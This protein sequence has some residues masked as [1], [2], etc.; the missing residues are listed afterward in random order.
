[1][2]LSQQKQMEKD[3]GEQIAAENYDIQAED[4]KEDT[5]DEED[6]SVHEKLA[7]EEYPSSDKPAGQVNADQTE[8]TVT[9]SNNENT[10]NEQIKE[11]KQPQEEG[12]KDLPSTIEDNGVS[13]EQGMEDSLQL[14][15]DLATEDEYW[16]LWE[17]VKVDDI[18]VVKTLRQEKNIRFTRFQ[19]NKTILHLGAERNAT[20]V[21]KYLLTD[22]KLDPNVKDE[23][24]QG[25][26]LHG[27][28]EYGSTDAARVLLQHGAQI[29]KQDLIG[30]TALHIACEHEKGEMKT[31]LIEQGADTS[32]VNSDGEIPAV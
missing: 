22:G 13:L 2:S 5:A 8:D 15:A 20:R 32:L 4:D 18:N 26:P 6:S 17:A 3:N 31:F 25:V 21:V 23:I 10:T 7:D 11:D 30:N 28:A 1:M 14:G 9:N 27:A 16:S 24:L 12:S 19:D 29:N